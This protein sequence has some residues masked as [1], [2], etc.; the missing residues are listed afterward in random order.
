M[1]CYKT[2]V[3]SFQAYKCNICIGTKMVISKKIT[4][5]E[6]SVNSIEY[7]FQLY[8]YHTC[9]IT[10]MCKKKTFL[11]NLEYIKLFHLV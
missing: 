1:F 4:R 3:Y 5:S 2:I 11:T 10:A 8:Q 7:K 9:T 6:F